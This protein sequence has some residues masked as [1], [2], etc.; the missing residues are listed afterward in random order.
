MVFVVH[1]GGGG[2]HDIDTLQQT[3]CA[4]ND[5]GTGSNGKLMHPASRGSERRRV[6]ML[7]YCGGFSPRKLT[8]M[9]AVLLGSRPGLGLRTVIF[10]RTV[11]MLALGDV[12]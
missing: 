4:A 6:S 9:S 11:S 1:V 8:P 12:P 7:F 3:G 5:Y 10:F 2:R